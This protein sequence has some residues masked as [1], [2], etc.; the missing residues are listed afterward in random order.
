MKPGAA[1]SS[2]RK[3]LSLR[4]PVPAPPMSIFT[5]SRSAPSHGSLGLGAGVGVQSKQGTQTLLPEFQPDGGG[6]SDPGNRDTCQM[7]PEHRTG[8]VSQTL[9]GLPGSG[10]EKSFKGEE[11][12]GQDQEVASGQGG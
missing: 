10:L 5:V 12:H 3:A 4:A 11:G 7:G 1:A 9:G 8:G 2:P 6:G